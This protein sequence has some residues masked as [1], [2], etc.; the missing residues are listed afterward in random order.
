M[1]DILAKLLIVLNIL[2]SSQK[3]ISL[4]FLIYYIQ[5]CEMQNQFNPINAGGSESMC[6]SPPLE[7]GLRE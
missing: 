1:H 7:K 6:A 2:K 4:H 5:V 3:S